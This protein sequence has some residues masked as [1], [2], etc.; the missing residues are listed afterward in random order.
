MAGKKPKNLRAKAFHV[1][2][3]RPTQLRVNKKAPT[4][5]PTASRLL[6]QAFINQNNVLVFFD[7][8]ALLMEVAGAG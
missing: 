8:K 5:L 4:P 6:T 7:M 2:I 1:W 3:T